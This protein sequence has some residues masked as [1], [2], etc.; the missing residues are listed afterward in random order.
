MSELWLARGLV[1]TLTERD[2]KVRYKRTFLG[3]GWAVIGPVVFMLVFTLF[4]QKAGHFATG[5]VPYALF[6]YLALVPWNF[7]SEA[8]TVGS[9]SLLTNIPLLNKVY[10]PREVFPIA[11]TLTAAFDTLVSAGVLIILFAVY[12]YPPAVETL[13]TP[14]LVLVE[15]AFTLGMVLFVSSAL[16]YLRDLRY[17]VPLIVQIGMFVSPVAYSISFIPKGLRPL[18][19]IL[20]PLGPVL[21]GF[22]RTVLHGQ[23]PAWGLLGLAA[24][25]SAA[26]LVGGYT[27]FKRLETGFADIA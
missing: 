21:E 20:D 19:A 9:T 25:S 27:V 10:C 12:S 14:L 26:W 13:W 24:L 16:V 8:V 18:Y 7:F 17:V 4:F 23:S 2:L 3:V 1:R 15:A 22:R 11:A 6:S 5:K